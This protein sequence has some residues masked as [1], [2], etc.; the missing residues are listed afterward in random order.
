MLLNILYSPAWLV[1]GMDMIFR[2]KIIIDWEQV[3]QLH[4]Q[5]AI[6]NNE[7]ENHHPIKHDYKVGDP[8]LIVI[9]PDD[10]CKQTKL[11]SPMERSYKIRQVFCN[12]MVR[13]LQGNF[14]EIIS[15][16]RQRTL[17]CPLTDL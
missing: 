10:P 3:K 15:I 1:F 16:H 11:S 12:G 8:V 5:Q 14:E 13:I 7:K 4:R 6:Q 17:Q 9:L 2:Q